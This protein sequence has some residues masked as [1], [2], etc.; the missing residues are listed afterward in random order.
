MAALFYFGF[1][2]SFI[3]IQQ[4]RV[5]KKAMHLYGIINIKLFIS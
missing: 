2:F 1:T 5:V 3:F 4:I